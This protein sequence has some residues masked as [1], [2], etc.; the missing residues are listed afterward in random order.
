MWGKTCL[1]EDSEEVKGLAE[2][3]ARWPEMKKQKFKHVAFFE[4]GLLLLSRKS[5]PAA[6]LTSAVKIKDYSHSPAPSAGTAGSTL[7]SDFGGF[8]SVGETLY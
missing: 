7:L 5:N 3:I 2:K 4:E 1:G 8:N 6:A